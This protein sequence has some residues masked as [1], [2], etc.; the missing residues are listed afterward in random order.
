M[1]VG[2]V[3]NVAVQ[4]P[5]EGVIGGY[6]KAK[7]LAL[8]SHYDVVAISDHETGVVAQV[9]GKYHLLDYVKHHPDEMEEVVLHLL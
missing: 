2:D 7:V 4:S 1:I 3:V 5:Q 6:L 9:E 8:G